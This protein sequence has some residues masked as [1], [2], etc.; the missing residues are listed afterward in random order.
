M[1]PNETITL[2]LAEDNDFGRAGQKIT[3]ALTPSDV[4]DPTEMPTYLAGYKPPGYRADEA[5][6]VVLV[7]H[8]EDKY[9]TFHSDDAFRA[10]NVKGAISGAIPEVDPKSS[11][12][13]YKVVDR[14]VGSFINAI[15]EQ[16]ATGYAPRQAGLRRCQRALQLD[17]EIDTWALLST[18]GNWNALNRETLPAARQWNGGATSDPIKDIETRIVASAQRVTGIWLNEE[19]GFA[20]GRHPLVK[21]RLR[22]MLG[23]Q[24]AQAILGGLYKSQEEPFDFVIPGLPPFHVASAKVKNET[25][26]AFDYVLGDDVI[27]VVAPPGVPR[28]GEEIATSYT[29]RRS[30]G[31]GVGYETREFFVPGRGPKGGTMIVCSMADIAVMTGSN[32]GGLIKDVLA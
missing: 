5:S 15:T 3:L 4:H 7:D 23:D 18:L 28:D 13:Q 32:C 16:N 25:T 12:A 9:R 1:P 22:Q 6:K 24:G 14:F 10:V 2:T 26:G 19:V 21:D 30:G 17:R 8:D 11:L 20:F 29:Y 31:A 27:L